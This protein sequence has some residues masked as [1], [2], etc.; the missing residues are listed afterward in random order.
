M[1]VDEA[2]AKMCF[3]QSREIKRGHEVCCTVNANQ[4]ICVG[5]QGCYHGDVLAGQCPHTYKYA[6]VLKPGF[7]LEPGCIVP[8]CLHCLAMC[9]HVC[10]CKCEYRLCGHDLRVKLWLEQCCWGRR[11]CQV[12]NSVFPNS[13][14]GQDC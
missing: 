4:L 5:Q 9:V 12:W 6:V 14:M 13:Q 8:V 7:K 3:F 2:S 1:P 10:L 11:S